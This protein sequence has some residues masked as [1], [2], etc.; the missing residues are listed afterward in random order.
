M[1]LEDVNFEAFFYRGE[2]K[3]LYYVRAYLLTPVKKHN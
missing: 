2:S 1:F 3:F